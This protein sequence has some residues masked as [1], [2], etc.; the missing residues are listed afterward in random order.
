M[1]EAQDLTRR[2]GEFTAVDGVSFS[3]DEGEIVGILGPNGAGKT[4]IIRMITGFLPPSAGRVTVAGRDLSRDSVAARAALGYLPENVALY[5]EMRVG[6]YLAYRARLEGVGRSET[7][8]RIGDALERCLLEDVRDQII[9]TLSKGYR[10]RVGLATAILHRPK[11]LVLDEPTIGLDPKQ[12]VAIRELIRELGRESTLVLS[13]HI[14]PEVELLCDRVMIIDRGRIVAQGSPES[15]RASS[16]GDTIVR[17]ALKESPPEAAAALAALPGV[18]E[19]ES[20][21]SDAFEVHCSGGADPR[22]AIFRTAVE[23]RWVLLELTQS[24]ASLE[25]VFVRLTT[26]EPPETAGAATPAPQGDEDDLEVT[27]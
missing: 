24:K 12:V 23:R 21:G 13:T 1:I 20:A 7:G 9:G 14:L 11:V 8:E 22:E 16:T 3:I 19:V 18:S 17:V 15:L 26:Q 2:Y 4:T 25:D 6:E 27:E 10:Q 5:E